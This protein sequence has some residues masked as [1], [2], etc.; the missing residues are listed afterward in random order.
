MEWIGGMAFLAVVLGFLVF[1]VWSLVDAIRVPDD[2]AFRAGSIEGHLGDRDR[3]DRARRLD[4]LPGH[5]PA[6]H[7]V[8]PAAGG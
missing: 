4:R 2:S 6:P 7:G 1:W 3:R 5:G 8:A